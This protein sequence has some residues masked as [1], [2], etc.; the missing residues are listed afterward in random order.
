MLPERR[1]LWSA[2][3]DADGFAAEYCETILFEELSMWIRLVEPVAIMLLG[4]FAFCGTWVVFAG[5]GLLSGV[6]LAVRRQKPW[7]GVKVFR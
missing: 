2:F 7:Q 5:A 3:A 6:A 1:A 4:M